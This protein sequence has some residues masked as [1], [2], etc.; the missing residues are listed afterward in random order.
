ML[1]PFLLFC[2]PAIGSRLVFEP[3]ISLGN[4]RTH[5]HPL[6]FWLNSKTLMVCTTP[7]YIKKGFRGWV[8][9]TPSLALGSIA[10]YLSYADVSTF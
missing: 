5:T 6:C 10:S 9:R 8:R 7:L 2:F 4:Q 1:V 3:P